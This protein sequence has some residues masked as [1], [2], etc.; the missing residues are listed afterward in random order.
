MAITVD[1]VTTRA[2]LRAFVKLP[3]RLYRGDPNWV[4]PLLSDDYRKLD[5]ARHPFFKHAAGELLLA[6]RDGVTAGRIV[7]IHDELWE[8][9]YGERAAYW[10]WFE[11]END[12]EVARALFDAARAWAKTR[13]ARASSAP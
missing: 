4:P 10:G 11:C 9:T 7:A 8:K 6:R 13:A 12:V 3:Y 1:P 2:G 5:R